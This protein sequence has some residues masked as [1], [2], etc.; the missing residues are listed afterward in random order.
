VLPVIAGYTVY[1]YYVFRGK[2]QALEY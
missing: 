1:A 2:A